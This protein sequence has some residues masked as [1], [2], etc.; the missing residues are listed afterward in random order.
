MINEGGF[1]IIGCRRV[2]K[3]DMYVKYICIVLFSSSFAIGVISL[4]FWI[5]ALLYIFIQI[6]S[7]L[8]C[9]AYQLKELC[10]DLIHY[11]VV[12]FKISLH[13]ISSM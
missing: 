1:T 11:D 8:I 10:K 4:K 7:L 9:I 12:A 2:I 13:I 5:T 6:G 3:S